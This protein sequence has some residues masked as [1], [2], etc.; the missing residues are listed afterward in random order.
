MKTRALFRG[1]AVLLGVLLTLV[2]PLFFLLSIFLLPLPAWADTD[3]VAN[4]SIIVAGNIKVRPEKRQEFIALSQTFIEP[5]RSEPGCISYSFYED[6]TED[7]KFLFFEVWRNRAALDY[8]F[9]TP[10]FHEFVEKS[11]DLLVKAA[12]IKVYKIAGFETL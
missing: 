10:Y 12:E 1:Q 7:N 3:D 4:Q 8:H 9:Q 2:I 6:E 5:S 11:P